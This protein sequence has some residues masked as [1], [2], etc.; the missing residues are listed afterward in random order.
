MP[1]FKCKESGKVAFLAFICYNDGSSET[2][3]K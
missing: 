3:P 2:I 1:K